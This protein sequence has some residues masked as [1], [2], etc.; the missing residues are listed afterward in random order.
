MSGRS[1]GDHLLNARHH[2][3]MVGETTGELD[4]ETPFV[5]EFVE[6]NIVCKEIWP[7]YVY[8]FNFYGKVSKTE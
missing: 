8:N 2:R 5:R 6:E 4:E 7:D 3:R 1:F